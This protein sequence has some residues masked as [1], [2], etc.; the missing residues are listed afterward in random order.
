MN[1]HAQQFTPAQVARLIEERDNLKEMVRQMEE[2]LSPCFALPTE[3]GLTRTEERFLRAIRSASP[4]VTHRERAMS[5][6][7]GLSDEVPQD[8]TLDV[9]LT[10]I[11]AKLRQADSGIEIETV[12]GRGWRLD[13]A[14]AGRFDA[15]SSGV[16]AALAAIHRAQVAA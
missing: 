7:Y 5:A 16:Q 12:W 11:R 6:V 13:A 1:V 14:N 8:R 9:H 4:N 15:A 10:K 2:A 3:W